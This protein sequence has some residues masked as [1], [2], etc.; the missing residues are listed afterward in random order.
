MLGKTAMLVAAL[1]AAGSGATLV[2]QQPQPQPATTKPAPA[3]AHPASVATTTTRAHQWTAT[4]IKDAQKGLMNAK[5]YTGKITGV[6][7]STT[8]SAVR[9]FQRARNL[10]VTGEL[11]QSLLRMLRE[12]KPKA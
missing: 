6:Y 4:E 9:E 5:L 11:N 10:P 2:A 12:E 8:R 3:A 1:L 7:D